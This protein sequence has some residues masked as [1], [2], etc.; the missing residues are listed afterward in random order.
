MPPSRK[1]WHRLKSVARCKMIFFQFCKHAR[2]SFRRRALEE[3][4]PFCYRDR[5]SS[6][7][8]NSRC[9]DP[10]KKS[11]LESTCNAILRKDL[12][13]LELDPGTAVSVRMIW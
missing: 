12:E 4:D 10:K 13:V 9:N 1:N 6:S 7:I 3:V 5:E 2:E 11:W 8:G